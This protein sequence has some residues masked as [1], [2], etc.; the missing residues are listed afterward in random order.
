[1][2]RNGAKNREKWGDVNLLSL[3]FMFLA[4]F[5]LLK[6]LYH[7]YQARNQ[8][9]T[10]VGAKRF[11]ILCPIVLNY[12]QHIFPRVAKHFAGG[13]RPYCALPSYGHG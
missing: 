12:V 7:E 6:V 11:L 2:H 8:L 4:L 3:D 10:P 9:G 13:N 5:S 1:M